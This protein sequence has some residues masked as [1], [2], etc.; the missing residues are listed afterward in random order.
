MRAPQA[1]KRGS[2]HDVDAWISSSGAYGAEPLRRQPQ[3]GRGGAALVQVL[4]M[5]S[6]LTTGLAYGAG[7]YGASATNFSETR[8]AGRGQHLVHET[9]EALAAYSFDT[10]SMMD[11]SS[12]M[13]KAT[14][15]SSD[16][17]VD[18]AVT[19]AA[20]GML[21]IRAVLKDN[22]TSRELSRL[23]TYR[24]RG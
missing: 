12:V 13:D 15:E 14:P 10:V 5:A 11:G 9:M 7:Q 4:I 19:P 24:G 23:V 6:V 20:D 22:R 21:T 1:T 16:F 17:R 3:R 8:R 18:L 2:S